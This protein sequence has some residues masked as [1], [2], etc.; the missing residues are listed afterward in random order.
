M[1]VMITLEMPVKPE[2]LE[3]YLNILKGALVE[4]RS[5]KGCRSVTT[6]VDQETSSIVLV[7]EWDSAEDQQAY[8]AWRVETGLIDAIAPFMQGELVTRTYDLKTEI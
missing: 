7:E 6:L 3:D 2:M 1:S 4:T 5:Y 8:I